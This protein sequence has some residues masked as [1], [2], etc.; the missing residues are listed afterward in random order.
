MNKTQFSLEAHCWKMLRMLGILVFWCVILTVVGCLAS[1][2]QLSL[3][4]VVQYTLATALNS[5]Y[6]GV[7]W[8]LQNLI[9]VYLI[10]PVLWCLYK[11]HGIIFDYFFWLIFFFAEGVEALRVLRDLLAVYLDVNIF[12][13]GIDA[14]M[15]FS[16]ICN[17]QYVFYFCMGGMIWKYREL[18]LEKRKM[19]VIAGGISWLGALAFGIF[20]S[21]KTGVLYDGKFNYSSLFMMISLLGL[22]AVFLPYKNKENVINRFLVSVGKNTLGIYLSHYIFMDI[23]QAVWQYAGFVERLVAYCI[24]FMASYIF[25]LGISRIPKVCRIAQI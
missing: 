17:L 24:I 4:V 6:T 25:T 7:L 20:I 8:F 5:K 14:L 18:L 11:D 19:W 21:R 2:E 10:F 9:A 1:G 22:F 12:N 13:N 3:S 16:S 15:R 23:L